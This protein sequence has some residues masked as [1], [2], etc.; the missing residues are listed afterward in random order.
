M[1]EN[2][3]IPTWEKARKGL[4]LEKKYKHK[5]YK[6]NNNTINTKGADTLYAIQN[7]SRKVDPAWS[8]ADTHCRLATRP[9]SHHILSECSKQEQHSSK[10]A[11]YLLPE[12]QMR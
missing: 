5:K 12:S 10:G 1:F 6:G 2:K 3:H 11:E 7:K 9:D 4:E 8:K